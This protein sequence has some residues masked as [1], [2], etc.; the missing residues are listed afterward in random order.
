[1]INRKSLIA[2]VIALLLSAVAGLQAQDKT[3]IC[4]VGHKTSHGFGNHEY[5]AGNHLMGELLAKAYPDQIEARYSVE[6]PENEDEFYKDADAVVFFCTGGGR[7][8]VNNHVPGFD[9]IMR[10]GAGLVC[11]HYGVEVPIGPSGKGMLA[12]MGGYF[13]THW[14][15]NPHWIAEFEVFPDHPAANGVKPFKMDDEWYFHM[16]FQGDMKGV[17]PILSAKAP[18]ETMKR[19]DGPHSGNPAV[20]KAVAAGESQ[21]VAWAY[22]RGE[23]YNNGRG[24]GFTGLHYHWNWEDDN[25]R[26]TVLNGVAW[27]AKLEIPENGVESKRPTR[28]ELEENVMK[29]GGA[30]NRKPKPAAA[31]PFKPG[32]SGAKPLFS[33]KVIDEKTPNFAVNIDVDF[34][35]DAK[36]LYLVVTDAGGYSFDWAD[37]CEPRIILADGKEKK[38]TELKWKQASV[39]WGQARVNQNAGGGALKVNGKPVEYGIGVHANSVIVYD[40]PKGAKKFNAR[41]GLDNGGTDQNGESSVQF[42]VY[43]KNPGPIAASSGGG[44]VGREASD[45]LT[46]MKIHEDLKAQLFASEPMMLSPSAIDV[47]HR[48]RVWVCEVINY[49]RHK[50]K[51]AE[52]DRILILED[53]NGDGVADDAK[54][55]Y[56]GNDVDSAHGICVLGD[57][58]II[59]AGDDVFSLY[60]KDGDD[61]AD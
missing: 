41:G 58:V 55:F 37:W 4:F 56:Q 46:H 22:Q 30:Q 43:D 23:D 54:V 1:M 20:R 35:N 8:L 33:S 29:H 19:K 24:F 17:T 57:R 60:D 12:W 44:N 3:V 31:G 21:H 25:F 13:E 27:V 45:A 59:S 2:A 34:S 15:V 38:L 18:E 11:L 28:E 6:W 42:H 32:K 61:K 53:K 47:D 51:R 9:K 52:G 40:L 16:R 39:G 14:S 10:T 49:R 48:G 50:G 7:H 26:K 5:N 36:E